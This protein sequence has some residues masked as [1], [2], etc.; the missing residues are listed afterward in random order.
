[1]YPNTEED[2]GLELLWWLFVAIVSIPIVGALV[3]IVV[4]WLI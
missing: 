1:M 2:G 3:M 4:G